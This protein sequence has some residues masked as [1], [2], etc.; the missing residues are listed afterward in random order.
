MPPQPR[1]GV[2]TYLKFLKEKKQIYKIIIFGKLMIY[3]EDD[4][5]VHWLG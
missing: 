5:I 2:L 1:L 4:A 3:Y